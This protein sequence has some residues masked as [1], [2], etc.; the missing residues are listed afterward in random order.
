M[1]NRSTIAA[2][3][4]K[5]IRTALKSTGLP[6][7]VTSKNYSM[8]HSV[9]VTLTDARPEIVEL[10]NKLACKF[11]AGHFDGMTDSYVHTNREAKNPTVDYV[12]V[13]NDISDATRQRVYEFI[14]AYFAGGAALPALY[15]DGMNK[16]VRHAYASEFVHEQFHTLGSA[17]WQSRSADR[18]SA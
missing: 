17:Y 16:I 8:G 11:Q 7:R 12:H 3:V 1:A 5:Q 6:V 2:E 4:A 14:R 15:V 18:V 13:N 10:V 9:S